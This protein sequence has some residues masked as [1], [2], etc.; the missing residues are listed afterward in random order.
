MVLTFN[1]DEP[2]VTFL[3]FLITLLSLNNADHATLQYASGKGRFIHQDQ[4]VEWISVST[5]RGGQKSEVV[6]KSHSRRQY[7]LQFEHS[8]IRIEGIFVAA[9][10]GRFDHHLKEL[11]V[12]LIAGGKNGRVR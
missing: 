12:I 7:L 1:G 9:A 10:L 3:F 11:F 8:I 4:N 2:I 6:R 5:F